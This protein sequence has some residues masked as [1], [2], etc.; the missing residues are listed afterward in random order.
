MKK[1]FLIIIAV[2]LLGFGY[3]TISPLFLDTEIS[4]TVE[5]IATVSTAEAD[6]QQVAVG[7]FTD[8]DSFHKGEGTVKIIKA[9]EKYFV[10][11]EDDFKVT[12]GPDLFVYFGKDGKYAKIAQIGRLKGNVGAQNYEVPADIDPSVFDEVWIWCRAFSQPFSVAKLTW[13]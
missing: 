7:T 4:E 9:G 2:L 10:R 3:W 1:A 8:V 12:N 6:I 11:F 13:K 5:D